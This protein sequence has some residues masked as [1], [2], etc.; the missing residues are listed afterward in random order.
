MDLRKEKEVPIDFL[1]ELLTLVLH[2]NILVFDG[3]HY[4]QRI[5]T[6]M[7]TRVAPTFACLFMGAVE[8]ASLRLA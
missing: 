2:C 4:H 7:G 3:T 8:T 1:I 6:A 5:G